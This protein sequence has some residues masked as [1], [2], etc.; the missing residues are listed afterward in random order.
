MQNMENIDYAFKFG[1]GTTIHITVPL[2]LSPVTAVDEEIPG[3]VKL[4]HEKCSNC[5]LNGKDHPYCPVAL[6]TFRIAKKFSEIISYERADVTVRVRDR[7]FSKN[8]DMNTSLRSLMGLCMALSTCPTMG[9]MRPMALD[10]LPFSSL[11]ETAG[12]VVRFYLFK[13]FFVMKNG[14]EPDWELKGLL[15]LYQEL[16]ISTSAFMERIRSASVKDANLNAVF[17]LVSFSTF[18][19]MGLSE[20]LDEQMKEITNGF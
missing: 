8:L 17:G 4:N 12:R 10:H 3:W 16:N 6:R 9:R 20:L 19:T 15:N 18:Y 2:E 13:Q 1:D 11:E 14:G 7:V 5:T